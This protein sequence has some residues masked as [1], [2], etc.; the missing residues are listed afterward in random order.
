MVPPGG[1]SGRAINKIMTELTTKRLF[2]KAA[3]FFLSLLKVFQ[4]GFYAKKEWEA[5]KC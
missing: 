5:K 4:E 1:N 3:S 2:A